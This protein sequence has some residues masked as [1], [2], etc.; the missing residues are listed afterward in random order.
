MRNGVQV[1]DAQD[2][3]VLIHAAMIVF[4]LSHSLA[5]EVGRYVLMGIVVLVWVGM[6][7]GGIKQKV[8]RYGYE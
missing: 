5:Q 4:D 7:W 6:V 2:V 8:M 1:M 3:W